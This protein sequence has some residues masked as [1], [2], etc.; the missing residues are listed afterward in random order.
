ME[1]Q[2]N[3]NLE[4][5]DTD[6]LVSS[7]PKAK[8]ALPKLPVILGAVAAG[9]VA[10]TVLL[11]ILLSGGKNVDIA[12]KNDAMPQTVFILGEEIDLSAGVLV[13]DEDGNKVELAMD[14]EGV[15]VSGYDK[16]T[17]GEQTITISYKDKTLELTVT[18]VERMQVIDYNADYLIG[19]TFDNSTGR[20]KITRDDGSNYT[21]MLKSDKV[22]ISGFNSSTVGEKSV[23][24]E[25]KSGANTYSTTFKV[26]VHNV[27]NVTLTRPTQ[28]NYNSH[29]S[30]INVA[31]GVLTLSALDG[32]VKKD[33]TVT[34]DMIE[35]FDLSAVNETNSPL[36]QQ[37]S[38]KYGGKSYNFDVI[39]TYTSV[40]KFKD[41]GSVVAGLDWSGEEEPEITELQGTTALS[42]MELYLA[43]SPAEQSLL[44]REETLNMARTAITYGFNLWANDILEFEGAFG[45]EYGEFTLYAES[46]EAIEDAIVK[47]GD[48]DRPIYTLYKV[49]NGMV[50]T[51]S[52]EE[53][54]EVVY[55]DVYFSNYPTI[56]PEIFE[57]LIDVFEYMLDLDDVMDTVGADW[58]DDISK[59]SEEIVDVFNAIV[60]S[61]YYSYSYAQFIYCVS[62]WREADDAFDFLYDYFYALGQEGVD[63]IIQLA[64]LR[65]PKQL[66]P[67]LAHL[68]EAM[69][70]LEEMSNSF[71]SSVT[72]AS[73]FLYSYVM[74][75]RLANEL[76]M[77]GDEML[78]TLFYGVPINSMLGFNADELY[79]FTDIFEYL[80]DVDGGYYTRCGALLG[81]P[82]FENFLDKYVDVLYNS[83]ETEGYT[84]SAAYRADVE[85]MFDHFMS[86]TPLQQYTLIGTLNLLSGY[87]IPPYAF[88][89]EGDY[90]DYTALFFD[91]ANEVIFG[92]FETKA[93]KDAY[94]NLMFA[95][96]AYSH[97][98]TNEQWL[99]DFN[100]FVNAVTDNLDLL[101][102]TDDLAVFN[103]K[104]GDLYEEYL[105]VFEMYNKNTDDGEGEDGDG[106][107]EEEILDLGEWE[108][109][110]LELYEAMM[111]VEL[112]NLFLQYEIPYYTLF[113]SAYERVL[114]ISDRILTEAPEDI[115]FI[116][117]H[118][119]L[120]TPDDFNAMFDES[121]EPTG[122]YF[123][124]DYMLTYYRSFYVSYLLSVNGADIFDYYAGYDMQ[125]FFAKCYDLIWALMWTNEGEETQYDKAKCLDALL[126]FSKLDPAAKAIFII[127]MEYAGA[128]DTEDSSVY[129]A[130]VDEFITAVYGENEDVYATIISL[131]DLEMSYIT[132]WYLDDDAEA[133]EYLVES[134]NALN[135]LYDALEG[136]DKDL[137]D[138]DFGAIYANYVQLVTELLEETPA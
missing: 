85:E 87:G 95:I 43:M 97:R 111:G 51:F 70:L 98:Y 12:F 137:F 69:S 39:I 101:K 29:D 125:E 82:G 49:I 135:D 113:F 114:A 27:E 80:C 118:M 91:I 66:E 123:S 103:G 24:V 17:L 13:V 133:R 63:P 121:Y 28:L 64:N 23:T 14:A 47:L 74:A 20:L 71:F 129:Y 90:A 2:N 99:T 92:M 61:D 72:D 3:V 30:G 100:K 105:A 75:V 15:T 60:Y 136:E 9:V 41:H 53:T 83:F 122:Q 107:D 57:E 38:V 124:F 77:S 46:R 21:V 22:T 4:G 26:N 10:I 108:D 88:D 110:F 104:F 36:T 138:E 48:T 25:Y 112:A 40:S 134:L 37:V 130:A 65:L 35:G 67:I 127:Y 31:G 62:E 42:M 126:T 79:Y 93:G 8:K 116:Y 59:Y 55:G 76:M 11:I 52:N 117:K 102:D 54:S 50:N 58:R 86:L 18:V 128:S 84:D 132:A 78:I 6:E 94:L 1:E 45:V 73:Q 115:Q 89:T 109:E 44:T 81:L 56:D 68:Y 32:K 106:E 16:N 19:D 120:Y 34:T 7:E 5:T 131:I 96:E 119:E 33:V